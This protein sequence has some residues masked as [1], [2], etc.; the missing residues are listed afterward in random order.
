M[1]NNEKD[2]C[3]YVIKDSKNTIQKE[4]EIVCFIWILFTTLGYLRYKPRNI[5]STIIWFCGT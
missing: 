1:W 3:V 2:F 5:L 4:I